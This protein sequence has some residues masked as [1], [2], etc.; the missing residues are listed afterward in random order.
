MIKIKNIRDDGSLFHYAH[1]ICDCLFP[2]IINEIYKYEKVV[3]EKNI[4]QTL[5]NFSKIYEDVMMNMNIELFKQHYNQVKLR[6]IILH[7]KKAYENNKIYFHKFRNY[8]FKRYNIDDKVYNNNYPE[9]LLIKR[10]NRV[11]LIDDKY[12]QLINENIKNGKERR[13][14]YDI[15]NIEKKLLEKYQDKFQSIY[16]ESMT[17][18]EQIKYFNNA[19]IIICAH[20]A[21]MSN[22]FFCKSNTKIVEVTCNKKWLFFDKISSNLD[23]IHYKCDNNLNVINFLISKNIL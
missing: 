23:L 21:C 2:E 12:L 22:M 15:D 9:V 4:D 1:F 6:P 7:K 17:F 20:G 19:K 14:I 3:R 13:E 18:E 11:N 5:G 16:L 8:I 10:G